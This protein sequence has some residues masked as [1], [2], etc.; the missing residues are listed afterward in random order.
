MQI[1]N[2]RS[3]EDGEFVVLHS[4][5]RRGALSISGFDVFRVRDGRFVEHW[6]V[7]MVEHGLNASGRGLLDGATTESNRATNREDTRRLASAL[8]E[9]LVRRDDGLLVG[10]A[11]N[12]RQH[13]PSFGDGR[14][15]W[16][17]S[18]QTQN[19][20]VHQELVRTFAEGDWALTQSRGRKGAT[21]VIVYDLVHQRDGEIIEHWVVWE[22]IPAR[23]RHNNGM[24]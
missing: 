4:L 22:R 18:L 6:D 19:G 24:L 5:Y 14:Q 10:V 12:V 3:F 16:L 9:G 13:D 11:E 8:V 17:D 2:L 23:M 21:P 15:A 1:E 20:L 7:G